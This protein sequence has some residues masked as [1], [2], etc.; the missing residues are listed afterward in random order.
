MQK[1]LFLDRDGVINVDF[2][3]VH[4]VEDFKFQEG[5]ISLCQKALEKKF[6]IVIITNQSGIARGMYGHEALKKLHSHMLAEFARSHIHI[7]AIYYCPHHPSINGK[8]L[9]RKPESLLF[10]KAIATLGINPKTSWMIGDNER[11][12]VPAKKLGIKTALYGRKFSDHADIYLDNL[13]DMNAYV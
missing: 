5:I 7:S 3:Y 11:D 13:S 1:A 9:C 8:C 6:C 10:E 4:K 2:G 12:L